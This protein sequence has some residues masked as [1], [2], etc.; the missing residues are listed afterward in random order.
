[1]KRPF[2][3]ISIAELDTIVKEAGMTAAA[4]TL[5]QGRPVVG[6]EDGQIV[7]AYPGDPLVAHLQPLIDEIKNRQN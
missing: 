4:E 2:S 3:T 1:M 7:T 6:M 5:A